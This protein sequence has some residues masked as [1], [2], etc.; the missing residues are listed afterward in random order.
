MTRA[1]SND[2]RDRRRL[3]EHFSFGQCEQLGGFY[4]A[5]E[6]FNGVGAVAFGYSDVS[7]QFIRGQ[8]SDQRNAKD[9]TFRCPLYPGKSSTDI[10]FKLGHFRFLQ[11]QSGN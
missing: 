6:E 1:I 8:R 10:P 9:L 2:T 11:T 4:R 5:K 3:L 7:R